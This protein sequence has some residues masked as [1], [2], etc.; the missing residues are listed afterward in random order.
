MTPQEVVQMNFDAWN[1]RDPA[2][3]LATFVDG[4]IYSDPVAGAGNSG[5]KISDYATDHAAAGTGLRQRF[6][7]R[8]ASSMVGG[9]VAHAVSGTFFGVYFMPIGMQ[10]V[11]WQ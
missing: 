6:A 11:S 7:V 2:A 4:G 10:W 5:S 8:V 9:H 1:A 3:I